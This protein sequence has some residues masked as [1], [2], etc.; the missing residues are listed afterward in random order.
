MAQ[1]DA[2]RL[3]RLVVVGD[4]AQRPADPGPLEEDGQ[5][6]DQ[7]TRCNRRPE[8]ELVD[9]D[10]AG[11]DALEQDQ[12]VFRDAEIERVDL[13]AEQRLAKTGDEKT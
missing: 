1:R 5:H 13:A 11:D 10:A 4:G 6:R 9:Q 3:R 7:E 12:R 8:I 2:D